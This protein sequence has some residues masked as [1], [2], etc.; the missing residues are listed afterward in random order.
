[1]NLTLL[2][3]GAL[4]GFYALVMSVAV[5]VPLVFGNL[6]I[7]ERERERER[8]RWRGIKIKT[9]QVGEHPAPTVERIQC[10]SLRTVR[11][12]V[13]DVAGATVHLL[14][15]CTLSSRRCIC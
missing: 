4:L 12:G 3:L 9:R 6:P 7:E 8:E 10:S 15:Q 13:G 14:T 1:M 5:V 2:C 11:V